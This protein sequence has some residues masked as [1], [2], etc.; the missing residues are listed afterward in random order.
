M[1]TP[2]HSASNPRK[3]LSQAA[4]ASI[5][6]LILS[7]YLPSLI[8]SVCRGVLLPVLPLFSLEL[9]E[10]YVS[11]GLIVAGE[12]VGALIGAVPAGKVLSRF[13]RKLT[14]L[15]GC[16]GTGFFTLS[17]AYVDSVPEAFSMCVLSGIGAGFFN[18]ACH[19]YLAEAVA[20][21]NRG[22]AISVYGG[23]YRLGLLAGPALGGRL[24]ADGGLKAPFIF[25]GAAEGITLI[26]VMLFVVRTHFGEPGSGSVGRGADHLLDHIR[27]NLGMYVPAAGG[28]LIFQG[29]RSARGIL[30]PLIGAEVLGLDIQ[31]VGYVVSMSNAVDLSLFF[32]AGLIMDNL[33]RKAAILPSFFIQSAG[34]AYLATIDGYSGLLA[35]AVLIGLGNGLGSGTMLTLS[36]DLAP[37]SRRGEF[38]GYWRLIGEGGRAGTQA[39]IG[40]VAAALSL[41]AAALVVAVLGLTG[42]ALFARFVPET[43]TKEIDRS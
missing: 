6:T 26:L 31:A 35:A 22:K 4:D 5:R 9:G 11:V 10:S 16:G 13:G 27:S 7:L 14:M 37:E 18:I 20:V 15:I 40:G 42:V 21:Q 38:L 2:D 1:E 32:P 3:P 39:M 29:T 36:A 23:I 17:L 34:I 43:L 19:A 12:G 30:I 24:A 28:F 8:H 25:C 33:G 41:S